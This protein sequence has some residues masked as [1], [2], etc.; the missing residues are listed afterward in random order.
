MR[1]SFRQQLVISVAVISETVSGI[2][3]VTAYA[4]IIILW[5][6][7]VTVSVI[8]TATPMRI[9]TDSAIIIPMRTATASATTATI[10]ADLYSQPTAHRAATAQAHTM[11]DMGITAAATAEGADT[12][13]DTADT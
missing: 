13:E 5:M 3:I 12:T 6:R 2:W 11:V 8:F 1:Q 9:M 7:M 4:E 10:T